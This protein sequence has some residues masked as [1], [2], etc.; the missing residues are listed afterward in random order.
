MKKLFL[1]V[2]FCLCAIPAL[3]QNPTCPTRQPYDNSNACASTA[4]VDNQTQAAA[5]PTL[6]SSPYTISTVDCG[7]TILA[8]GGFFTVTLPSAAGFPVGCSVFVQNG[9]PLRGKTLSGFPLGLAGYILSARDGVGVVV[10]STGVWSSTKLP[11]TRWKLP[12]AGPEANT[13]IWYVD[14]SLGSDSNDGLAA[15]AGAF[16]T[17][18]AAMDQVSDYADANGQ[19]IIIQVNNAGL[20]TSVNLKAVVGIYD[21]WPHNNLTFQGNTSALVAMN[22]GANV[23]ITGLAVQGWIIQGFAFN[24]STAWIEA[25]VGA[26]IYVGTNSGTGNPAFGFDSIY[27]ASVIEF[28]GGNFTSLN[29]AQSVFGYAVYTGQIISAGT[30]TITLNNAVA[31]TDF[32]LGD[33]NG[34]IIGNSF[35]YAGAGATTSTGQTFLFSHGAYLNTGGH[36]AGTGGAGG[37]LP[38]NS[39][40][41]F[42]T[43]YC[44]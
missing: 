39:A 43:G 11:L 26:H 14:G 18:Q 13:Y 8:T 42:T 20:C 9:D 12:G 29:T 16:A 5:P 32:F 30:S 28:I 27:S 15:G 33:A 31:Y 17:C 37:N 38:G 1:A 41:G 40:G 36:C 6:T 35:S 21:F 25:D 4:Y 44:V 2:L 19:K 3:A 10:G 34:T 7:H 24:S 23:C 22:C